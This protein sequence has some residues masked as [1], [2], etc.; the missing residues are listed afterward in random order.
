MEDFDDQ[1][2]MFSMSLRHDVL[3]DRVQET[4]LTEVED[5]RRALLRSRVSSKDYRGQ[6]GASLRAFRGR[7]CRRWQN[8][9]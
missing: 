2:R 4:L 5:L 3:L 1:Q 6:V 9:I 8:K 7:F